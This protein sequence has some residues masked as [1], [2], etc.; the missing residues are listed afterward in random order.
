MT[1]SALGN[2]ASDR[3][4]GLDL[5]RGDLWSGDLWSDHNPP[6]DH[7]TH[8]AALTARKSGAS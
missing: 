8:V 6:S 2:D 5:N 3:L 1:L 7:K 4:V